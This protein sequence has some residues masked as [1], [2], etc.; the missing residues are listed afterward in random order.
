VN[1]AGDIFSDSKTD[2]FIQHARQRFHKRCREVIIDPLEHHI[3][4]LRYGAALPPREIAQHLADEG[5]LI[6][7]RQPTARL[8]SD[9]LDRICKRLC[10]DSEIR[11]LLAGD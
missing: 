5:V 2:L 10:L 7:D 11:D 3:F 1:E 8:V 9:T 6:K 4:W